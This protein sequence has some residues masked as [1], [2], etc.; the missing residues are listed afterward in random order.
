MICPIDRSVSEAGCKTRT[1][2]SARHVAAHAL[3]SSQSR[4]DQS[5]KPIPRWQAWL[6]VSWAVIATTTYFACMMGLT[7]NH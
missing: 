6:F 5:A 7:T 2:R 4:P 1:L 3:L